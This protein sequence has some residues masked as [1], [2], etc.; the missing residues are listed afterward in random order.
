M[1]LIASS[2]CQHKV[3]VCHLISVIVYVY[4]YVYTCQPCNNNNYSL[5]PCSWLACRMART[6]EEKGCRDRTLL[7]LG[8]LTA[9]TVNQIGH[10]LH[11][12]FH[13]T[14]VYLDLS[15]Y[16]QKAT[17]DDGGRDFSTKST[18]YWSFMT[19]LRE[20]NIYMWKMS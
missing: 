20:R 15:S 5:S 10:H 6:Q 17:F 11:C 12:S 4:M 8:L 16:P 14:C 1:D 9:S 7:L 3:V 19:N 2:T 18:S 13:L